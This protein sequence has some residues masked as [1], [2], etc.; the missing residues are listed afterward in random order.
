MGQYQQ[1]VATTIDNLVLI[2]EAYDI[3]VMCSTMIQREKQGE[4]ELFVSLITVKFFS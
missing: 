3:S 1:P 2:R 4:E